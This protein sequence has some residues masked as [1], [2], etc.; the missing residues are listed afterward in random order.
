MGFWLFMLAMDL[1]IPL[2]MLYFG[3]RFQ[4][5]APDKINVFFGYRTARSMKNRDTWVFAHEQTGRYWYWAGWV[6]LVLTV[7]AM[8]LLLGK[9]M[10][11]VSFWGTVVCVAQCIPLAGVCVVVE[12]AL[13]HTFDD[14][15]NRI[16]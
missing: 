1:L 5:K 8:L 13:K 11:T 4:R 3:H 10:D 2:T 12:Q 6:T 14:Y 16:G 15:G 9:D 7:L